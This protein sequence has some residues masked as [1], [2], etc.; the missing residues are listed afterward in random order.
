MQEQTTNPRARRMSSLLQATNVRRTRVET[1]P[2]HLGDGED[3]TSRGPGAPLALAFVLDGALDLMMMEQEDDPPRTDEGR[4]TS[5][6][7][8]ADHTSETGRKQ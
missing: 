1:T 4:S 5:S 6:T 7:D 2:S 3:R 8:A